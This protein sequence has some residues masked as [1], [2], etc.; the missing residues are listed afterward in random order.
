[1]RDAA[2]NTRGDAVATYACLGKKPNC[3]QC[4]EKADKIIT[5][6]REEATCKQVAV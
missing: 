4:L 2:A 5:E 6:H 3:G 1:M